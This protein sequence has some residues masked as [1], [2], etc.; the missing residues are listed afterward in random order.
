MKFKLPEWDVEK[1]RPKT[2]M[3]DCPYCKMDEL[4]MV[5]PNSAICY[6]CYVAFNR[7][8]VSNLFQSFRKL[9]KDPGKFESSNVSITIVDMSMPAKK[10][11]CLACH[12]ASSCDSCCNECEAP[13][14]SGQTC[15]IGKPGQTE[16]LSQIRGLKNER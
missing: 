15:M 8:G 13:C 9:N 12:W 4:G 6:N 11:I 5:G 7:I 14:N 16:R 10:A 2:K 1:Q 3:P